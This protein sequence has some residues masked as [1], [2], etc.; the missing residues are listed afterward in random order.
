[1]SADPI[2]QI[3]QYNIREVVLTVFS[4]VSI[5]LAVFSTWRVI[6]NDRRMRLEPYFRTLWQ[7]K[8]DEITYYTDRA[9]QNLDLTRFDI[10]A[11]RHVTSI[12]FEGLSIQGANFDKFN[13]DYDRSF[14]RKL[15]HLERSLAEVRLAA[16]NYCGLQ[17]LASESMETDIL[18]QSSGIYDAIL[19]DI[20]DETKMK[21]QT[22]MK[23]TNEKLERALVRYGLPK[24]VSFE[25]IR[26]N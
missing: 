17:D 7:K 19:K 23:Q 25:Q 11:R 20:D 3:G 5:C 26:N 14:L 10:E 18:L 22:R 15:R 13:W 8:S 1:M 4:T 12:Y 2:V 21:R 16:S 24:S 9:S 6:R